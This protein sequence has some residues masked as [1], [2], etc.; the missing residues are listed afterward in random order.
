[1][2]TLLQQLSTFDITLKA[3]TEQAAAAAASSVAAPA[4]ATA[5]TSAGAAP[6][7]VS[8]LPPLQLA[9]PSTGPTATSTD[10]PRVTGQKAVRDSSDDDLLGRIR[11]TKQKK[12]EDGA[13][14][15]KDVIVE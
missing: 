9:L 6:A 7:H 11:V 15:A 3:C 10:E 14:V 8:P 13:E 5:A 12:A 4:P 2:A 1:M